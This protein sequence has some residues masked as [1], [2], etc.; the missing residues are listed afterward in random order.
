MQKHAPKPNGNNEGFRAPDAAELLKNLGKAATQWQKL[1][2]DFFSQHRDVRQVW[3]ID[4]MNIGG[5][6]LELHARYLG[7][8]KKAF[9]AQ[10]EL[11]KGYA[12]LVLNAGKKL[13]GEQTEPVAAPSPGDKRFR[14]KEWDDY[15]PFDFMKQAYLLS[16]R[17]LRDTVAHAPGLDEKTRRKIGFF[18]GQFA[19]ALAP[20]NFI[21]TNPDV[22]KETLRTNGDNLVRGLQNLFEDLERGHGK[23]SIAQTDFGKFEVGKNIATTPGKVVYENDLMQLIQYDPATP[24]VHEKPLLIFPPLINKFYILDLRPENSFIRWCVAQGYTVFVVSWANPD[25]KLAAKTFE[26]YMREG[27]YAALDAAEKATGV[28]GANVIGYCIGGTLLGAT[29][30][31][32]SADGDGRIASATFF[33]AQVDFSEPGD[34]EVF[35]DEEQLADLEKQMKAAGGYLEGAAMAQTFNMLRANDLIWSFVVNNYLMGR[36]PA[37]FDL[38]YWNADSTRMP[39]RMHMFYLR[40]CYLKNS[41]A[42]GQM[43]LAGKKLDLHKIKIPVFLQSSR[44]DHIAPYRSVYKATQLYSGPV[45]FIVAGSGHI[46]GV[47]NHPDAKKYQYWTNEKLPASVDDWWKGAVEHP[48]S[49]WPEWERWLAPKSGKMIKARKPGDGKLKPIEAAPGRYVKVK[50]N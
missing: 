43:M 14:S 8:P 45:K 19:D 35:I 38:L 15:L 33:A 37:P 23:L 31:H 18:T 30:A 34:L 46:A 25:A 48:G 49:W 42:R 13:A 12:Q 6:F 50:S 27:I 26:D 36:E 9:E 3:P 47:I 40:E 2:G 1:V 4:P 16:A 7:D 44:E 28:K 39:S 5:A 22:L 10:L 20:T 21:L 24:Q 29:L 17:W 11:W 41:M 32:M